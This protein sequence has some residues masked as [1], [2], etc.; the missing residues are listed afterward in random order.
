MT[1]LNVNDYCSG[2]KSGA[3]PAKTNPSLETKETKVRSLWD[4]CS[5]HWAPLELTVRSGLKRSPCNWA[6]THNAA[7]KALS[8]SPFFLFFNWCYRFEWTC[9]VWARAGRFIFT[10]A[11]GVVTVVIC[12]SV[13]VHGRLELSWLWLRIP[14]CKGLIISGFY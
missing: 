10:E 4:D 9:R 11:T 13:H 6:F 3:Q 14:V 5:S 2:G 1:V 7:W 12:S 8:L